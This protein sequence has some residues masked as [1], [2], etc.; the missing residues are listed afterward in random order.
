MI[1]KNNNNFSMQ[2]A[3]YF[4]VMCKEQEHRAERGTASAG[5]TGDIKHET[6]PWHW[7]WSVN[8]SSSAHVHDQVCVL[9]SVE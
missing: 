2:A 1:F 3:L 4:A 5:C 6:P 9:L 8:G 7:F